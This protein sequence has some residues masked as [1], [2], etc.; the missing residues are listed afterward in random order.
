MRGTL[1]L[2]IMVVLA[3]GGD[4]SE[5]PPKNL[6]RVTADLT[7]AAGE[8]D[9]DR[10]RAERV[11]HVLRRPDV[12]RDLLANDAVG[13][14]WMAGRGFTSWR[15]GT[16]GGLLEWMSSMGP[17]GP[18][19]LSDTLLAEAFG[20]NTRPAALLRCDPSG[21]YVEDVERAWEE[22]ADETTCGLVTRVFGVER[23]TERYVIIVSHDGGTSDQEPQRVG[24]R[25]LHG[26]GGA[27]PFVFS[28][29]VVAKDGWPDFAALKPKRG[30]AWVRWRGRFDP[31]RTIDSDGRS[32]ILRLP[33]GTIELEPGSDHR[34]RPVGSEAG[35]N[36]RPT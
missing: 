15:L 5:P 25:V 14:N 20:A 27:T 6:P 10:G 29:D 21:C 28:E 33:G 2:P 18:R 17:D 7:K 35:P 30:C 8:M 3:C 32:L 31:D 11:W 36:P 24:I 19:D 22:A 34:L 4:R 13:L 1:L 23:G 9:D 12:A 26:S 16:W